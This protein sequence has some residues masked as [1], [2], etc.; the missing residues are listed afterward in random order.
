MMVA[1]TTDLASGIFMA[2]EEGEVK[3]MIRHG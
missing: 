2:E 1:S 3:L